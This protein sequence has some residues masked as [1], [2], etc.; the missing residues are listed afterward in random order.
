MAI[1]L[2]DHFT[3]KK[4]IHFV[5]PCIAMMIVTS[6]YSIVDGFF[7][8]NFAGK[9]AFA[10]VNLVMPVLMGFSS[11]GFMIGTGGSALVAFT[12]GD[13]NQEKANQ[14]F[15][16]LIEFTVLLGILFS[17]V[18][19]IFMPQ[20]AHILGATELIFDD[21]VLY[22]RI[23]LVTLT[24][25]MLAN[26]FQSFLVTA[27]RAKMGLII[28]ITAGVIN[29]LLDYLFVGVLQG[30][31][32]GAGYAT[33]LSQIVGGMIPMIYF[34]KRNGSVLRLRLTKLDVHAIGK[35]CSNGSSEM[36]SNLSTSLIGILYNFQLM[37]YASENGIAAYGVIMYVSF[38]FIAIFIGYSIG[39]GPVIG[40]HHGANHNIELKNILRKSLTLILIVAITMTVLA[41]CFAG[42]V[43]KVFVGYDPILMDMTKQAMTIYSL[44][45]LFSGFNIFGSAFFTGLNNGKISAIISFLRTWVIEVASILLLP[46][47]LGMEGVWMAIVLAEGVALMVT[48]SML[49]LNKKKYGY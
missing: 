15:S 17:V 31:I 46:L 23:L 7:V 48:V 36:M 16:M 20:I 29:M 25:Y 10:A 12:L 13:G 47:I 32:A 21:C 9:N 38:I 5:V 39:I 11:F 45:F 35:A 1:G 4:L 22:G 26:S 2:A 37:K 24:F 27:E 34:L 6:L 43:A 28:T 42:P 30:G 3:Y 14:I 18:G 41:E 40:Y 33:A 8:S 19:I 44:S 49:L